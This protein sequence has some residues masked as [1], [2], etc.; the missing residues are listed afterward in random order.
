MPTLAKPSSNT[1][2]KLLL[3]GDS[4]TGKTGALASLVKAGFHLRIIDM[5]NKVAGGI[6]PQLLT[7]DEERSRVQFVS[8]RDKFKI[9]PAG[10][11]PDGTPKAFSDAMKAME[12]W[13]DDGTDPAKWGPTHVLVLDTLTFLATAA[14]DWAKAMNPT[15]KEP[16]TW[17]YTAQQQ[18]EDV[19]SLLTN[20][21][22]ATNV[23][24][25]SHITY[26]ALT[27]GTTKGFPSSIGKAI[28]PKLPGFFEHMGVVNQKKISF[29]P[30]AFIDSKTPLLSVTA[31]F[32]RET[33][34][35][36]FFAA[37]RK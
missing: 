3:I 10:P 26:Q 21:A 20:G 30:T 36:D 5:D 9:G 1:L 37:A 11:I 7:T 18:I 24:V 4:G 14:Y 22:F 35:A 17:F 6:L 28:G 23:I 13:P 33:G 34:L 2:V 31:A 27:E 12:K 29:I 19:V 32:P 16:R 15:A 25:T 8:L